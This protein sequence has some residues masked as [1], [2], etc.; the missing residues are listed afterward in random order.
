MLALPLA[1]FG[2]G[3]VKIGTINMDRAFKTMGLVV[4]RGVRPPW[5]VADSGRHKLR[6]Y[7]VARL[8]LYAYDTFYRSFS[9]EDANLTVAEFRS[10]F[11]IIDG[12][13][14]CVIADPVSCDAGPSE[15]CH[16]P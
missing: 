11:R 9:P 2:Q 10:R 12:A 16:P 7:S 4:L 13:L 8:V 6:S 3:T 1:A 15:H 14:L 5:L